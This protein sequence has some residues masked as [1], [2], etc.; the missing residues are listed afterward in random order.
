MGV[1]VLQQSAHLRRSVS[2]AA[3]VGVDNRSLHV[4]IMTRQVNEAASIASWGNTWGNKPHG[5][6]PIPA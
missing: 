1:A 6:Q 3:L 4:A 2:S 5:F